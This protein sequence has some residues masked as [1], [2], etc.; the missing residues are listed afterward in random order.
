[1]CMQ[2]NHLKFLVF[3]ACPKSA[4]LVMEHF[5]YNQPH[6][7]PRVNTEEADIVLLL[8]TSVPTAAAA[9]GN[10]Q[11]PAVVSSSATLS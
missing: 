11:S 5:P 2:V 6:A 9:E 3:C 1:M 7:H 4:N 10:Q 8:Q